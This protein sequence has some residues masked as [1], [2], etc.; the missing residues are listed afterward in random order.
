MFA[1]RR[2]PVG[3]HLLAL[4]CRCSPAI[5]CLLV[6]SF[7]RAV[8]PLEPLEN[9]PFHV[10]MV[11][12]VAFM[13]V[14][15]STFAFT[16]VF[17]FVFVWITDPFIFGQTHS[18]Q[19]DHFFVGQK[20]NLHPQHMLQIVCR[21]PAVRSQMAPWSSLAKRDAVSGHNSQ[22]RQV[23]TDRPGQ[24]E[25]RPDIPAPPKPA[26][27]PSQATQASQASEPG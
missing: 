19:K 7:N 17:V 1:C 15:G 8:Q 3:V 26:V 10:V 6:L 9:A 18:F 27:G 20:K 23:A 11:F 24:P 13:F 2:S 22:A 21:T 5:L 16:C 25:Y 4:A 14:F 12:L